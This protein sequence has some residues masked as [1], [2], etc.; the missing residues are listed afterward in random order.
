MELKHIL[1]PKKKYVWST[2]IRDSP[3]DLDNR[4]EIEPILD[5]SAQRELA[6]YWKETIRLRAMKIRVFTDEARKMERDVF[7]YLEGKDYGIL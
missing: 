4:I 7:R 3:K 6:D 1:L 2:E 5:S